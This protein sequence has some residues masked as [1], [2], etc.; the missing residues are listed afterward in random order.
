VENKAT[1]VNYRTIADYMI[2]ADGAN[3]LVRKQ[4]NIPVSGNDSWTDLLNIYFEADLEL[5]VKGREFSLFL[6]D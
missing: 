4:L 5:L 1:G 2:A 6:I 3:S